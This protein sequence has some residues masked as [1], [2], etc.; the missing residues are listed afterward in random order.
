MVESF[1]DFGAVRVL[2]LVGDPTCPPHQAG[3]FAML[4]FGEH[5]ARPYSIASAPNGKNLEFHIK[6]GGVGGSHFSTTALKIGDK[7]LCS[8]IDGNYAY[9]ASCPRPLFLIAGGT[10]L[11]PMLAMTEASLNDNPA[12]PIYLFYGGR[13]FSELY[14]HSNLQQLAQ[15]NSNLVYSPALSDEKQGTIQYGL[16][17]DIALCHDNLLKSRLYIAGSVDMVRN[18]IKAALA[19]GVSPDVIHSDYK[20]LTDKK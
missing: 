10:G 20:E 5:P 18:I 8:K 1:K 15:Q 17:G 3:Q 19:A 6:G 11:A 4:S 9:I 7:V 2:R 16:I 13:V 14:Y 12:R